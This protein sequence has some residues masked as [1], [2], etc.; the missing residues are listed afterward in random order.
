LQVAGIRLVIR[1]LWIWRV[2]V[3]AQEGQLGHIVDYF[4]K[5][6]VEDG[7]DPERAA[8]WRRS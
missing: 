1:P 7:Y 5:N 3:R 2:L 8:L 4:M 6:C